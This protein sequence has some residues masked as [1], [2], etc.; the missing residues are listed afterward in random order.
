M[1]AQKATAAFEHT[2]RDSAEA[3]RDWYVRDELPKGYWE[4]HLTHGQSP[5]EITIVSV[6]GMP[7]DFFFGIVSTLSMF[8]WLM[9]S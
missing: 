1:A 4:Q 3:W 9:N 8:H 5:T 2:K 6:Y 7:A